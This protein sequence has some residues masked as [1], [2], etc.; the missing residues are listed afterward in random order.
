MSCCNLTR[1]LIKCNCYLVIA[2]V[3]PPPVPSSKSILPPFEQVSLY[4][5][6]LARGHLDPELLVGRVHVLLLGHVRVPL[7][8]LLLQR[9]GHL[10]HGDQVTLDLLQGGLVVQHQTRG[11]SVEGVVRSHIV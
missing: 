8:Q 11:L 5:D 10:R 7:L 3:K 2:Q 6:R 9:R 1:R 4:L